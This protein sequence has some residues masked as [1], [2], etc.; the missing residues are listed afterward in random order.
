MRPVCLLFILAVSTLF[1]SSC[2]DVAIKGEDYGDLMN[3]PDGLNLTPHEHKEGWGK[4]DCFTC[5]N[6]N[7]I[8]LNQSEQGYDME[9]VR[10]QAA[11]EGLDS[12]SE[13]HGTN[14]VGGQTCASCH[15]GGVEGDDD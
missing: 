3:S 13:C 2:G 4:T 8:H 11:D 5:H 14:G 1:I 9:A 12:C 7:L 6:L 15:E 10:D